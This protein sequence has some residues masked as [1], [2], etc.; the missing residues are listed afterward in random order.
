MK[1]NWQAALTPWEQN[2]VIEMERR[3]L[4]LKREARELKAQILRFKNRGC[5]RSKLPSRQK[6]ESAEVPQ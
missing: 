4:R 6:P 1:R 3:V 2:Y 5:N